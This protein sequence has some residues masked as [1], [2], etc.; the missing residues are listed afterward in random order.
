MSEVAIERA[1]TGDQIAEVAAMV[2]EFF[3]FVRGRYPD[4]VA[5][6]DDY[7]EAQGVR[8]QLAR[9]G[10]FFT[11]PS[12]E[13]FLARLGAAPAGI[14]MLRPHGAGDGELNR[15]YVREAARGRGLGRLLGEAAVA[16]A[17]ALGYRVLYLDALYRH[18]EAL[19]LYES[20]G[21]RYFTDPGAFGGGD[22]RVIHMKLEL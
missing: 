14:V 13:C 17:R 5:V 11:P 3:D 18:H 22:E 12:G 6:I 1:R 21:F 8:E 20:L 19:P 9:F 15:M 4:M 10:E 2:W 7:V 16:E